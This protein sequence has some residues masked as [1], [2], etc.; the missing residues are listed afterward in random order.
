MET[1]DVIIVGTGA[2]GGTLARALA[3]TGKRI[4]LLERGGRLPREK[5]NW[6]PAAVFGDHRYRTEERWYDADGNSFRPEV[7]Y[8][9]GGNTK[10]YGAA[11]VRLRR[12][13]FGPVRH[14]DGVSPAW[15]IGYDELE[16]YYVEAE[17]LYKVHGARGI[18]PTEPP[19]S[20]DY[21]FAALPHEARVE[22][23]R[24]GLAAA[25][26]RPFPL[27]MGIDRDSE[28]PW[29]RPCIRCDTCDGFPCL[30]D[31]KAD[32]QVVAVDEA[33]RHDNVE[34]R[35]HA[36][37][38][39]LLAAAGGGAVD[40][41]EAE[42]DG[43]TAVFRGDIVVV[44]CGA[45]NSAALLLGSADGDHADGLA[46]ASGMVGR[47]LMLHNNSA[48]LA[49]S[50]RPNPTRFQKTL[51][52]NDFYFG[53]GDF[54]FPLGHVQLLGKSKGPMLQA[55]APALVPG[56][57]LR[58]L[59]DHSVD[60][61]MTT[62]DLPDPDNRV[63]LSRDGDIV[64]HYRRN[65]LEPHRRLVGRLEET[66]RGIGECR[67]LLPHKAYFS[68]QLPLAAVCHQ[69]GTCRFGPDPAT[70][71]LDLHCRAHDLDNLYVVDGSFFPSIS[72]MNPSLT[73]MANALRVAD[74]LCE[75][76]G[77]RR[78]RLLRRV[79]ASDRPARRQSDA[80]P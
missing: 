72:S 61:W 73:I 57:V 75:R 51:G 9:V 60:W 10:V 22:E 4:L 42:V 48:M 14:H 59:A 39:R 18:D 25:G 40:G 71:V 54:D 21:A 3:P 32:A 46:N 8:F 27:P 69:V 35:T 80:R 29:R 2:G 56:G 65:N 53:D 74:H 33:E 16:P 38:T 19:A 17:H 23:V 28:E 36:R 58:W 78:P 49:L 64:L 77:T 37:V 12:E 79:D 55:D 24:E 1:Y 44:S 52:L 67:A 20:D 41:V 31:A 50:T 11:L 6:D 7:A 43:G 63:E 76:L 66:L 70:S 26:L 68:K 34:L 5:E 47:N 15:P 30:V 13:D 62:E 45:I